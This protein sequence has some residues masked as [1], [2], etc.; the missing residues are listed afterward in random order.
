VLRPIEF[1]RRQPRPTPLPPR[2]TAEEE[3]AHAAFV[4]TLGPNALWLKAG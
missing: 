3:A 1:V 2:V 4:A